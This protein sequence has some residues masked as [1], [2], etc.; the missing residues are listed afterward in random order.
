MIENFTLTV[1]GG[2]LEGHEF[3]LD[4]NSRYLIG[5]S[6][7]C[8]FQ[9]PRDV[10][11]RDISRQHCLVET[12]SRKVFIRDLGSLHGTYVNGERIGM[13]PAGQPAEAA[14]LSRGQTRELKDG[15]EVLVGNT[16]LRVA[17]GVPA[18]VL[19]PMY[20]S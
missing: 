1:M 20:F 7:D 15:D 11:P 8:D 13:R 16:V 12:T 14:D 4:P 3:A 5:R 2:S 10:G 19:Q 18:D 6:K 17:V 9:L